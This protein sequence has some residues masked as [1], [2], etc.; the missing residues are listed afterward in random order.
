[1]NSEDSALL[2][3]RKG[4]TTYFSLYLTCKLTWYDNILLLR[5]K[6]NLILKDQFEG[7]FTI[8]NLE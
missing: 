3:Q 7:E 6:C 4:R 8:V 1:M 2:Y 5:V